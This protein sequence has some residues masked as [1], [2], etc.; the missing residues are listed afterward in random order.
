MTGI[1]VALDTSTA[2]A[3]L[4]NNAVVLARYEAEKVALPAAV[5][6]ELRFAAL[7]SGLRAANVA[8]YERFIEGAPFLSIDQETTR[9]YAELRFE[10]KQ[11]GRPIPMNDLWIAASCLRYGMVLVTEDRH[12]AHC[13]RLKTESW[14]EAPSE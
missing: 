1:R 9:I 2:V 4:N 10:L 7:N 11:L 12:F 13:P 5:V 3:L 8:R 14:L 6:A